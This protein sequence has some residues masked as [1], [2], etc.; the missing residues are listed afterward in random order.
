[1]GPFRGKGLSRLQGPQGGQRERFSPELPGRTRFPSSGAEN[2]EPKTPPAPEGFR[3]LELLARMKAGRWAGH[4]RAL[5]VEEC[6]S[7]SV[8]LFRKAVSEV[9]SYERNARGT[10]TWGNGREASFRVELRGGEPGVC[11]TYRPEGDAEES[12]RDYFVRLVTTNP[13]VGGIR[14]WFMCPLVVN[15]KPC[16]KRVS[17]LYLPRGADF[18]GCRTCYR[19]TY[20]SAQQHNGRVA[21]FMKDPERTMRTVEDFLRTPGTGRFPS[22]ALSAFLGRR[23]AP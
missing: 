13:P 7:L 22:S 16:R 17:K 18:F 8:Q 12:P 1:M 5:T 10:L 20:R 2:Q 11:L 19:L 23:E 3:T 4:R 15:G 9:V 21:A 14:W 6:P